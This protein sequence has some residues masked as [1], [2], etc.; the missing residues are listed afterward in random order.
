MSQDKVE[1]VR[2]PLC[3][4]AAPRR[5][6]EERLGVRY[7]VILAIVVRAF[8]R[9]PPRWRL[10][11]AVVH[12]ATQLGVEA[13][14][15][16]DYEAAFALFDPYVELLVPSVL[17]GMG[18]EPNVHGREARIRFEMKWRNEWGDFQYVPEALSDL[19]NRIL[20]T[21]RMRGSGP[22]SGAAFDHQWA[23]LFTFSAG[24]VVREQVFLDHSEALEAV[25][26]RE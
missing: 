13:A 22:G 21:G 10:R 15:R 26:L 7:P 8:L 14:N 19:G 20:V 16:R 1:V 24:R 12:R 2:Q 4:A 6:F 17:A 23:D 5:R 3:V 11:R 9:L 25:G 18:F